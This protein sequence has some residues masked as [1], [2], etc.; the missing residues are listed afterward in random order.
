MP[1]IHFLNFPF[2]FTASERITFGSF[3]LIGDGVGWWM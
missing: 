1:D 3:S 2:G